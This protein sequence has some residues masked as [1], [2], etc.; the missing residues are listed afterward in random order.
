VIEDIR[1]NAET[2]GSSLIFL[3]KVSISFERDSR[4]FGD[5]LKAAR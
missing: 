5:F 3:L 4:S 1:M 2:F